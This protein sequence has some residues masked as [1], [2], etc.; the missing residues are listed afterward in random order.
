M[1]KNEEEC[2][3]WNNA[4]VDKAKKIVSDE[5]AASNPHALEVTMDVSPY[6]SDEVESVCKRLGHRSQH[7]C[8]DGSTM[9]VNADD[10]AEAIAA[11]MMHEQQHVLGRQQSGRRSV[12]AGESCATK[13]Q[14]N[15]IQGMHDPST[16]AT[17]R[18][19]TYIG[20][21]WNPNFPGCG[22]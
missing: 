3:K 13:R 6:N 16:A 14:T 17:A 10:G 7:G 15:F 1:R 8:N 5:A 21:T 22:F 12:P 20:A 11:I 4:E 9:V 18:H 2:R 19:N